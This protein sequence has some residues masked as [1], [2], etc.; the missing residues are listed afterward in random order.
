MTTRVPVIL[1]FDDCEV[2]FVLGADPAA[3]ADQNTLAYLNRN[4]YCEPE[5]A[6]LMARVVR[7]GDHVLD[8]GANIGFFTLLLGKLVGASGSVTSFEP[9]PGT[10]SKLRENVRANGLKHVSCLQVALSDRV[11]SA[12]LHMSVD[13]GRNSLARNPS[14]ISAAPIVTGALDQAVSVKGYRLVKMDAEGAELQI[15]LGAGRIF[16]PAATPY[17]VS[18]LNAE[19]LEA[20]GTSA[21][22]FR[23]WMYTTGYDTFLLHDDGSLPTWVPRQTTIG[24]DKLN[25][26]VLFS[27]T[28]A[29][30]DAWPEVKLC[31]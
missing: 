6:R 4:G 3:A 28:N 25:I 17:I 8:I 23:E 30:A 24:G 12:H 5:V 21:R 27:T 26:N 10:F 1:K 15:A 16:T 18:E 19:A 22:S 14:T 7:H 31:V 29:V 11:K 13:S 2:S 20:M 9:S